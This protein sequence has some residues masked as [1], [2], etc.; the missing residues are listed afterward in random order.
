MSATQPHLVP[1]AS[2][3]PSTSAEPPKD[4]Q[5]AEAEVELG[6]EALRARLSRVERKPPLYRVFRVGLYGIYGIVATW[7][8]LSITVAVWRT[9]YGDVGTQ[10]IIETAPEA[11]TK[12]ATA[13]HTTTP[14]VA[15]PVPSAR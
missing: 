3:V 9:V 14:A 1:T 8:V 2:S 11:E 10:L 12:G 4:L 15:A 13:T 7:L 6:D 5:G